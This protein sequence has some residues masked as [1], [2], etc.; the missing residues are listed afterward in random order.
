[1]LLFL[2]IHYSGFLR[3]TLYYFPYHL[4]SAL[5]C[6]VTMLIYPTFIFENKK[7]KLTGT[8][9]SLIIIIIMTVI[10]YINKITYTTTLL[11]NDGSAGAVFDDSYKAYLEDSKLGNVHIKYDDGLED[12]VVVAEFI[13]AGKTNLILE[14]S[15]GNK[16]IFE[17]DAKRDRY[18]IKKIFFNRQ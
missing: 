18:D 2:G 9:I 15:N 6:I 3:E 16:T 5:F 10:S 12:Y 17:I 1:M 13:R 4:L 8:I 14:D 11:T 7:I